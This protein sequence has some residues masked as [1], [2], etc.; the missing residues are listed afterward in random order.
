MKRFLA[1]LA[2]ICAIGVVICSCSGKNDVNDD[3]GTQTQEGSTE[4]GGADSGSDATT[5][6][7]NGS[8]TNAGG[9]GT[10]NGGNNNATSSP[11]AYETDW[12]YDY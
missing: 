4:N 6:S 8:E 3:N 10:N 5:D 9:N 12:T 11:E 7:D 2:I 1:L